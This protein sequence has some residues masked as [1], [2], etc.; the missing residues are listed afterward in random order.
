MEYED[1][2]DW[3]ETIAEEYAACDASCD[4]SRFLQSIKDEVSNW[5]TGV[6]E[7]GSI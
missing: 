4:Y 3:L 2:S 1:F 6:Q 7:D 5:E